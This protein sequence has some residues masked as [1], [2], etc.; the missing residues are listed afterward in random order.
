MESNNSVLSQH[1]LSYFFLN[2]T[3]WFWIKFIFGVVPSVWLLRDTVDVVAKS[4]LLVSNLKLLNPTDILVSLLPLFSTVSLVLITFVPKRILYIQK[5]INFFLRGN[6]FLF[7][8][9]FLHL[10]RNTYS[11]NPL[12]I[13]LIVFVFMSP[14]IVGFLYLEQQKLT[15]G[16][17]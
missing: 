9:M 5:Y 4:F 8:P 11:S 7:I 17:Q 1:K 2:T 3:R 10:T 14:V 13:F 12:I 16:N 15:S 6:V